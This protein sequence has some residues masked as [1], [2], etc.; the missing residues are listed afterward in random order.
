MCL[1]FRMVRAS[2]I[3]VKLAYRDHDSSPATGP[4]LGFPS[5]PPITPGSS[6]HLPPEGGHA[7]G[8][9]GPHFV[10]EAEFPELSGGERPRPEGS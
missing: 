10:V 2:V 3:Y 8:Q 6:N 7:V 5:G 1:A 4:P 9:S